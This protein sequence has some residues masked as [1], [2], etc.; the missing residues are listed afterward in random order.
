MHDSVRFALRKGR[1]E[2]EQESA[3]STTDHLMITGAKEI[4]TLYRQNEILTESAISGDTVIQTTHGAAFGM[5]ING[6]GTIG[7]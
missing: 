3:I 6:D 7:S 2:T 4:S 1:T 5:D